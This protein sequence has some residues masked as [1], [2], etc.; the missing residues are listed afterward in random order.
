MANIKTN[1]TQAFEV[2]APSQGRHILPFI[3]IL[4]GGI[5]IL[6]EAFYGLSAVHALNANALIAN[7]TK[8][9]SVKLNATDISLINKEVSSDEIYDA[10]YAVVGIGIVAGLLLVISSIMIYRAN[11]RHQVKVYSAIAI[12]F[13]LISIFVGGGFIIGMALGVIGGILGLMNK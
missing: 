2:P 4:V 3:F 7:I 8:N 1:G 11:S 10:V 12:I 5:L 13:G 6:I 9:S